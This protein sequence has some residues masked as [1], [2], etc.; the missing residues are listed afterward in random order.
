MLNPRVPASCPGMRIELGPQASISLYE[1]FTHACCTAGP[2]QA[3]QEA[4]RGA[5]AE[6]GPHPAFPQ[7]RPLMVRGGRQQQQ[8]PA[9]MDSTPCTAPACRGVWPA[10]HHA[11]PTRLDARGRWASSCLGAG[12]GTRPVGARLVAG[13]RAESAR[14]VS[15][16]RITAARP[17]RLP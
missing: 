13:A 4:G 6:P 7:R 11:P 3:E 16:E 9:E 10:G 5:V 17:S 2:Q 1:I 8:P 14:G 12:F 15:A